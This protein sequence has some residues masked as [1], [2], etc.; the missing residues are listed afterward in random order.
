MV[1]LPYVQ[2]C[3]SR[4]YVTELITST[5]LSELIRKCKLVVVHI[6]RFPTVPSL[7]ANWLTTTHGRYRGQKLAPTMPVMLVAICRCI[8]TAATW[9]S[10]PSEDERTCCGRAGHQV[11][12]T[13]TTSPR[14]GSTTAARPTRSAATAAGSH[15]PTGGTATCRWTS[16]D[17]A[18][19]LV[20]SSSPS[21]AVTSRYSPRPSSATALSCQRPTSCLPTLRLTARASRRA[22]VQMRT[23][24][25]MMLIQHRRTSVHGALQSRRTNYRNQV[26]RVKALLRSGIS[27]P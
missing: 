1:S 4:V 2:K 27:L 12:S 19:P 6:T 18:V 15:S 24:S 17:A 14:L 26:Y 22:G 3:P 20:Q 7:K 25:M 11:P 8:W 16:I 5:Y 9:I 10:C 21:T 23:P 13:P